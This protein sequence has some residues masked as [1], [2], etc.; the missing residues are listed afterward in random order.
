MSSENLRNLPSVN[1]LLS[2]LGEYE[3][4]LG[5][6][7]IV[8]IVRESLQKARALIQLG[9]EAPTVQ[10][11]LDEIQQ[12]IKLDVR[13]QSASH[14]INAT[15]IILHTNLGRAV[16]SKEAQKAMADVAS[17]YSPLEFDLATG[18]RGKRGKWVEQLIKTVTGAE[19]ALVVNN[20]AAATLLMLSAIAANK[21]VIISRGELVEIG[22]GF[23]VP[24]IMAQSGA[25][26]VE[27]GTT[28]RTSLRD[29]IKANQEHDDVGAIMRVHRS[30]FRM[31]G[32]TEDVD[33]ADLT[34]LIPD[35]TSNTYIPVLD[36]NGSGALLDTARF[37][38]I[39]EPMPQES[40]KAGV[41]LTSFSGDKL[42]GG[43]QAG[44][45]AGKTQYVE[46]CR[47]HP[48]ARTVRAD[49]L[50]LAAL[51]ATLAH[52]V[53]GTAEIEVPVWRM[54]G[55]TQEHIGARAS[56][57]I[58]RTTVWQRA[59]DIRVQTV[60]GESAIGGGSLA[61]ETLPTVLIAIT[62]ENPND[63]LDALRQA[64]IPIIARIQDDKVLLDMRTVLDDDELI[65]VLTN[66]QV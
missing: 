40:I 57:V 66:L 45:I 10:T 62:T 8:Q 59:R 42:L 51:G 23:R 1:E 22:G 63:L 53:R 14:V 39:H 5:H 54:V 13:Q 43:P 3:Y 65:R 56:A 36:D 27:V 7:R 21:S 26:L 52:Y 9:N 61:G 19:D 30:N 12:D 16:L 33:L 38:L 32:F 18:Q 64:D 6:E 31:I 58:E 50:T 17:S 28:N 4:Q 20:C 49:K 55:E 46:L 60:P 47:K 41:A 44:I 15:G 29:F 24:E 48:L 25:R 11:L 35:A 34:R 2:G 37:G